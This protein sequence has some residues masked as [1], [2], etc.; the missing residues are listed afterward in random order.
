MNHVFCNKLD[1]SETIYPDDIQV[2][3]YSIEEH[4]AHLR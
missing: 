3:S 1:D 2:L 4:E